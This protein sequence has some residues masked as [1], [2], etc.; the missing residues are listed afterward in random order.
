MRTN[1]DRKLANLKFGTVERPVRAVKRSPKNL[2]LEFIDHQIGLAT[3]ESSGDRFS[4]R[5]MRYKKRADGTTYREV[6]SA[7]PR[8]CFWEA[9]GQWLLECRYGN[10]PI[11]FS[12]GQPTIFAGRTL[13]D[14]IAVL[15]TLRAADDAGE[16]DNAI[17]DA[18]RRAARSPKP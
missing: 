15:V 17:V 11:E 14:V 13:D 16:A 10:I 5:R 7:K 8:R 4:V 12:P 3:A 6:V 9:A 18:A 1:T 2:V